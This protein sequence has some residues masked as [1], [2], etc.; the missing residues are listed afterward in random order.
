MMSSPIQFD[1]FGLNLIWLGLVR[2]KFELINPIAWM[3]EHTRLSSGVLPRCKVG[4]GATPI[5]YTWQQTSY[6]GY[7]WLATQPSNSMLHC[8][9]QNAMMVLY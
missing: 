9:H 8:V 7:T 3:V 6:G 5:G 2:F 1:S 4:L